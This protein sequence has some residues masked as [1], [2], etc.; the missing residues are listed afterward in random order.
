MKPICVFLF[1]VAAVCAAGVVRAQEHDAPGGSPHAAHT[2]YSGLHARQIKALSD[3]QVAELRAGKGMTLALAAELNG[4]PGPAHVLE[5]AQSLGLSPEQRAATQDLF[6]RMQAEASSLGEE[7]ITAERALD[8]LFAQRTATPESLSKATARVAQAQGR[9]REAHL[10][11]H[12]AMMDVLAAEQ[13]AAY[14]RL[15]GY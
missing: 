2:P 13:I 8:A 3:Q 7:V 4:Y 12:L 9:L 11:Y 15:R 1:T 14:N 5:L 6:H 10:R